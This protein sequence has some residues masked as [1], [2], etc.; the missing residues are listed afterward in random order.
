LRTEAIATLIHYRKT[1]K[2]WRKIK[3]SWNG[4]HLWM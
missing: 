4:D 2:T 1:C 3:K